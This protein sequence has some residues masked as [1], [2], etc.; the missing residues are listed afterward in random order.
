MSDPRPWTEG[1]GGAPSDAELARPI[2]APG[3]AFE[4]LWGI[5]YEAPWA[6]PMDG[7]ARHAR[8]QVRA[9]AEHLPVVLRPLGPMPMMDVDLDPGVLAEVGHLRRV[10][11]Q[12]PAM[13]IVQLV[14]HGASQL[15]R[16]LLP[17]GVH[18]VL[19]ETAEK[20]LAST[21]VYTSW[22]RTTVPPDVVSL[23]NR[24][25]EVWTPC[26]SNDEVFRAAGVKQTRVVPCPYHPRDSRTARMTLPYSL[27]RYP[28]GKRFYA[29]GK[30]EPRKNFHRLIGAFLTVFEPSEQ[31]A[32]YIKTLPWGPW[33]N[34]PSPH[35]SLAAWLQVPEIA[36]KWNA[37]Q[38][39][40]RVR[41]SS[42]L[43]TEE[44]IANLHAQNNIYV[45]ASHGEAWDLPAFDAACAGNEVLATDW[46]GPAMYSF[47][48]IRTSGLVAVDGE[49]GWEPEA[50][51][52][53]VPMESIA[54]ALAG[55]QAPEGER[56]HPAQLY[57]R[58]GRSAVGEQM[59]NAVLRHVDRV[60]GA[61]AAHQLAVGAGFGG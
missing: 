34:F 54:E 12:R 57:P 9:L 13:R 40:K 58:F 10:A 14:I 16:I 37:W 39:T 3:T 24:C 31:A 43:L 47:P 42:A 30:W 55:A 45:S 35:N 20:M 50:R 48:T 59:R 28:Q 33:E 61:D 41:V 49:Y 51:W 18:Q 8:A 6:S 15:E 25:A 22:E 7:M 60:F 23:L 36:A 27:S 56:Q 5:T 52:R 1:E 29:I 38:V 26:H 19:P 2:A 53:D 4:T 21:I 11:F 17:F 32:L 44:G 46:G